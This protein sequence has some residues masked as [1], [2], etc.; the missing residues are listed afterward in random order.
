MRVGSWCSIGVEHEW[1]HLLA[2]C[3]FMRSDTLRPCLLRYMY[4]LAVVEDMTHLH[5]N[6]SNNRPNGTGLPTTLKT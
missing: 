5:K 2:I 6:P 1:A 4:T 3:S